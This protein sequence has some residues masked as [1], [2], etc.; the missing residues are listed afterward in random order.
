MLGIELDELILNDQALEANL[1]NEGG[2]GGT[3]RFLQ[4]IA[5][6]WLGQQSVK[7]WAEEG[8]P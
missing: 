4:N 7:T 2:Y 1:T 5:G 8:N 6:L 3:N